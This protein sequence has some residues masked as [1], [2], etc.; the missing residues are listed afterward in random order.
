[1]KRHTAPVLLILLLFWLSPIVTTARESPDT[2]VISVIHDGPW[3]GAANIEAIIKLEIN[4]LLE[5]E[6]TPQFPPEYRIEADFDPDQI[7]QALRNQLA[8]PRVDIVM[9]AGPIG[10]GLVG[11]IDSLPKPVFAPFIVGRELQELPYDDGVS[12][13]YNFNYLSSP[14]SFERDLRTF[15]EIVPVDTLAILISDPISNA[16]PSVIERFRTIARAQGVVAE[17]I[18]VGTE[19]QPAL[20]KIP[21]S[22][23]AA[24]L[25]IL[26]HMPDFELQKLIDGVNQ[27][28]LPSFS[29]LGNRNVERGVMAALSPE[30]EI[31]RLSRRLAL[32]IQRT[33]LGENPSELPVDVAQT[34]SLTLNMETVR[35]IDVWPSWEFITEA[36]VVGEWTRETDRMLSLSSVMSDAVTANLE[37]LAKRYEVAAGAA[38]VPIARSQLLPQAEVGARGV[39]IDGDRA[40]ASL[41]AQAERSITGTA[42]LTQVIYSEQA[43][44]NLSIQNRLQ[45][46]REFDSTA[47]R[48]DIAAR[49][50]SAYLNVL[51]ANTF[52]RIQR[53]NLRTTRSNL[54][55]AEMRERIGISG[56]SEVLRWR[57]QIATN[58]INVINASSQR[59]VTEIEL[60]RLL[61]QPLESAFETTEAGL[62]D[63]ALLGSQQ[64]LF[65]YMDN[66]KSFRLLR[67]ALTEEAIRQS[68]ELAGLD[69]S[70]AARERALKSSR[71][72]FWT[73]TLALKGDVEYLFSEDGEGVSSPF[74]GGFA[75]PGGQTLEIPQRDDLNWTV[76]LN[77][78]LPLFEGLKRP[79]EIRQNHEELIQLRTQRRATVERIEQRVRSAAHQLGASY[80]AIRLSRDA[81]TAADSTLTLV[82]DAYSRGAVSIIDLIDAQNAALVA[83]QQAANAVYDALLDLIELERAIGQFDLFRT[84]EERRSFYRRLDQYY[85]SVNNASGAGN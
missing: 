5:G 77:L 2:V 74:D 39:I 14:F 42:S 17:V 9:I 84:D 70:I 45:D 75:L 30:D 57:S 73:P 19:A 56:P 55:L 11:R 54:E 12:G 83:E 60:N 44:A 59:N 58:R 43:W 25:G 4:E 36:R 50:G 40:A 6:F 47:L 71:W 79:A 68:P 21:E 62:D 3:A 81:E 67:I 16:V 1:M 31:I 46:A 35:Q 72:Q 61:N 76:A 48:L 69:A 22:A 23:N 26:L 27:R 37:L 7:E 29:M 15:T 80:A 85:G 82:I 53:D 63:P 34:R 33:L 32:N 51:R 41:G 20:E 8:D 49:A 64:R 66:P 52:E 78:S 65:D 13:R 38:D 18:P 24:Y 28:R 10:S